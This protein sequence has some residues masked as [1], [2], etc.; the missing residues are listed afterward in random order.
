MAWL[1][2]GYEKRVWE[3][4]WL[5]VTPDYDRL[6]DRPEFR[7]I[8]SPSSGCRRNADL[9]PVAR[10]PSRGSVRMICTFAAAA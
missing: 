5:T 6:R 3:M 2:F 8:S 7:R 9:I 10:A 1:G 4:P